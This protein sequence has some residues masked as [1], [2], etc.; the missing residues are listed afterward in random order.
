MQRYKGD[1]QMRGKVSPI[2]F[3]LINT[4]GLSAFNTA[5]HYAVDPSQ[6]GLC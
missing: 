4:A 3:H 1:Q 6:Y 2:L 5:T